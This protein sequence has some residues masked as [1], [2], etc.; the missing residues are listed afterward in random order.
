MSSVKMWRSLHISHPKWYGCNK[1]NTTERRK[2]K[3]KRL[4]Y[5]ILQNFTCTEKGKKNHTIL[6]NTQNATRD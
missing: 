4:Q 3:N 2:N 6:A 5:K 1:A